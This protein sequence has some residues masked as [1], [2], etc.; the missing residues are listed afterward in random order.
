MNLITKTQ[1]K[2]QNTWMTPSKDPSY[3]NLTNN[4]INMIK[5][6]NKNFGRCREIEEKKKKKAGDL[7]GSRWTAAAVQT[8]VLGENGWD[9]DTLWWLQVRRGFVRLRGCLVGMLGMGMSHQWVQPFVW[10]YMHGSERGM[11]KE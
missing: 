6:R 10:L 2:H 3:P 11:G 1:E 4:T 7:T 9:F 8:L 5:I